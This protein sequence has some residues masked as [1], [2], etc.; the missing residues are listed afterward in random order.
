MPSVSLNALRAQARAFERIGAYREDY[1]SVTVDN[2][3][4]Q[5]AVT[6]VDT[7]ILTI[8]GARA[9]RGRLL[10]ADEIRTGAPVVLVSDSLWR[11]QLG[12]RDDVL[13][14]HVT[15]RDTVYA[16]VGVLQ[17]GFRFAE[18]SDMWR[19]MVERPDTV[20]AFHWS[21][22]SYDVYGRLAPGVSLATARE[23][24]ALIG[25]RVAA[26]SDA[27]TRSGIVVQDGMLM[28]NLA[29]TLPIA[30]LPLGIA[31]ALLLIA[32]VNVGN[33][34]TV[35]AAERRGEMAVRAS[36]GAT[37]RRLAQQTIAEGLVI[38]GAAG[39]LGLAVSVVGTRLVLS[40]LPMQGIPAWVR[41]GVDWRVATFAVFAAVA[42]VVAFSAA[43]AREA[44]RTNL[45]NALR[46]GG[47]AIV[48]ESGVMRSGRR[49][50]IVQLALSLTLCI[51]AV[52]CARSYTVVAELRS[53]EAE[54]TYQ[55]NALWEGAKY[56]AVDERMRAAE[57][58]L[59]T[60]ASA[61]GIADAQ[62]SGFF[63][64][65]WRSAD[66]RAAAAAR[67][68][69]LD[70]V[71]A[72]RR[73]YTGA[74]GNEPADGPVRRDLRTTVVTDG[75]FALLGRPVVEGRGFASADA[76]GAPPV[77][78]V[79]RRL[80]TA[81]W[82]NASA[83]GQTVRMGRG[84]API[85]VVGVVADVRE[86]RTGFDGARIVNVPEM[87]FSSRQAEFR[88][89]LLVRPAHDA[90]PLEGIVTDAVRRVDRSISVQGI[91]TVASLR[92]E[93]TTLLQTF[94]S[95]LGAFSAGALVLAMIGIYAVVA[96]AV[97]QR[98]RE[99]GLRIALG[100]SPH[101]LVRAFVRDG[102]RMGAIGLGAGVVLAAVASQAMRFLLF[103]VST[104]DP[105]AYAIGIIAFAAIALLATWL[106]ARRAAR[107][108]PLAALRSL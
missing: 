39:A 23:E 52:L 29:R 71:S 79:S 99:I 100:A 12:A 32:A 57:A 69:Q 42:A 75:Y 9:Q 14:A 103:G 54:R 101:E 47:D 31:F 105:L 76:I 21:A 56:E 55:V 22:A 7:A 107:V 60:V 49:G 106:P 1:A 85:L 58:V 6:A 91:R 16:V 46:A 38:G 63:N 27:Y 104:V 26:S 86:A 62:L 28:R 50:V 108:D 40:L 15:M 44:L 61:P 83:V 95:L 80:A 36:L 73:L 66:P 72:D 70:R 51:I 87:F 8:M 77:A 97:T 25:K 11:A 92:G 96:Y 34:F 35:R 4:F 2:R 94:G 74:S 18:R 102:A 53:P 5:V 67:A 64:G 82:P 33:L 24:A 81:L 98:T 59:A 78:V 13:S 65:S 3:R 90:V 17:P 30:L 41:F 43:P 20:S 93:A 19:P 10:T 88:P 48:V 37:G 68:A 45:S 84:G 89:G